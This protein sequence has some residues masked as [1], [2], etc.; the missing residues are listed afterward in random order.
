MFAGLNHT[1]FVKGTQYWKLDNWKVEVIGEPRS[2]RE[3]WLGCPSGENIQD[4]IETAHQIQFTRSPAFLIGMSAGVGTL[5]IIVI[6]VIVWSRRTNQKKEP[7]SGVVTTSVPLYNSELNG[8]PNSRKDFGP[9]NMY[10]GMA[11]QKWRWL[12][13]SLQHKV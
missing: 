9:K 8:T 6:V 5:I 3:D 11:Q 10:V 1:Y 12:R 7:F 2:F 13:F 4:D